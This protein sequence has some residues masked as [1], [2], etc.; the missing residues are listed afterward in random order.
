MDARNFLTI[1]PVV[2]RASKK[3]LQLKLCDDL[4]PLSKG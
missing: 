1:V 3:G 4:T 2:E